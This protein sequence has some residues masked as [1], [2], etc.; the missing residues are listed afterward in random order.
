MIK[1]D[2]FDIR[3]LVPPHVYEARGERAWELIDVQLIALIDKL[4]N[5]FG[6]VYINT[7]HF[8]KSPFGSNIFHWSGL[9]TF[10]YMI[11][12]YYPEKHKNNSLITLQDFQV[13]QAK[14]IKYFSQHFYGR[15]ADMK[16]MKVSAEEVRSYVKNHPDEFPELMSYELDTSWFHGDV[17]NCLRIKTYTP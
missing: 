15:A 12:D 5:K 9:R 10:Q 3:E 8:T 6:T 11:P 14:S 16:F 17:R 13:A 1:A 4:A 7:W 2:R